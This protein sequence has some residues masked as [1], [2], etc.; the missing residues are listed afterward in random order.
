MLSVSMSTEFVG[1]RG[2]KDFV[3]EKIALVDAKDLAGATNRVAQV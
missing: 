2:T 1:W 3:L